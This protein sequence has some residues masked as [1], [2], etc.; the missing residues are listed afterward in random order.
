MHKKHLLPLILSA[1][2]SVPMH[3]QI[4]LKGWTADDLATE[5]KTIQLSD[6]IFRD[7]RLAILL[8]KQ[9]FESELYGRDREKIWH[10][11]D[12]LVNYLNSIYVRDLGV[13]FSLVRDER[14]IDENLESKYVSIDN[15][16]EL[17][18]NHIGNENYDIGVAEIYIGYES[19][20]LAGLANVG[21]I[22]YDV[23]K[24]NVLSMK[25]DDRTI[26]HEIGHCLGS[27]HTFDNGMGSEPGSGQSIVG[28]GF[29]SNKHF[30]SLASLQAMLPCVE[31]ADKRTPEERRHK[32]ENTAPRIDRDR[33][34]REYTVPYNTFFS[35]PVYA[36]DDEQT[37]LLYSYNQWN[38]APYAP[39][40]FPTFPA[41]H[42][43]VLNFGRAY[44]T[45]NLCLVPGSDTLPV[46]QYKMLLSVSDALPVEEAIEKRQA[47]LYD[48][49]LTMVNVVDAT[50]FKITSI[51][52][53]EYKTGERIDL[54]WDVDKNFF[55]DDSKV[56]VLLSDDG[57]DT[58]KHVLVPSTANDGECEIVMPQSAIGKKTT[59]SYN[60]TPIYQQGEAVIRLEVTSGNGTGCYDITDNN[61]MQGGMTV[62]QS[63]IKF[64]GMPDDNYMFIGADDDMPA[65]PEITAS[66]NGVALNV[67]F[68][69]TQE[70][71]I[72]RR[73]WTATDGSEESS[74]VQF[75]ERETIETAVKPV[76]V[77]ADSN[78]PLYDLSGRRIQNPQK[79][80]IYI[81]RG[82]KVMI[83]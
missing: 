24:G 59:Y 43:N 46:G 23:Y 42:N 32:A 19:S 71:N 56:R 62:A 57:G 67:D 34:Q 73:L 26:A 31:F 58:F 81:C 13:K 15:S 37:E 55:G 7:Y 63:D 53:N 39:A 40:H 54:R 50:P 29:S 80:S 2:L 35:I 8:T 25:Q 11:K 18:D 75:I 47:P 44:S 20:G 83:K 72:T 48:C 16:T 61:P 21:G 77:D 52:K 64:E 38:F 1:S 3:A 78:A 9:E 45:S 69:E 68:S 49:Y 76:L 17:I 79:G 82:R 41:S 74:Y 60:D 27:K 5:E 66:K 12:S 14:L 33:M 4:F 28:Y 36:E 22:K 51:D 70:G 65:V 10:M 30:V 6:G